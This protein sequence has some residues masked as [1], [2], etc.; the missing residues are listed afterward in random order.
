M[1]IDIVP[2]EATGAALGI[3]GMASYIGAGLQDIISGWFIDSGKSVVDGVTVYNFDSVAIFWITA[4]TL[5]AFLVLFLAKRK[6]S[7][8]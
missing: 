2:R 1:A 5:S 6:N 8:T 3:V 4:S 7:Q